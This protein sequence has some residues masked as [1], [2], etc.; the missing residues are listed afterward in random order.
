MIKMSNRLLIILIFISS[1]V[2][3]LF[4]N[5]LLVPKREPN[6][7]SETTISELVRNEAITTRCNE[8]KHRLMSAK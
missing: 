6:R 5:S 2:I 4:L 8:T 3:I 7:P 1:L